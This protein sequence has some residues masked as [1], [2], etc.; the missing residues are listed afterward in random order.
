MFAL[1]WLLLVAVANG[2]YAPQQPRFASRARPVAA[3]EGSAA[4]EAKKRI[5]RLQC[6]RHGSNTAQKSKEKPDAK[7]RATTQHSSPSRAA[8]RRRQNRKH[9]QVVVGNGM[10]GQR[11]V[12]LCADKLAERGASDQVDIVSFCEER[13][14][15]YNRVRLTSWFETRDAD[16]LSLVGSYKD[17]PQ[18]EWYASEERPN[19]KVRV[20]DLATGLDVD[21]K[22]VACGDELVSYDKCVLATGSYPFVPPI[23]GK[24]LPGVFVYRTID[25][26]EA[27][28]AYQKAHGARAA[29]NFFFASTPS[30]R[31][32]KWMRRVDGASSPPRRER[33]ASRD[34]R[35]T[36]TRR[37]RRRG[38]SDRPVDQKLTK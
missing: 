12:E 24:D 34:E 36:P 2:L 13:L 38:E 17:A 6:L 3:A 25:D 26:L 10:V 20:G 11:L 4:A 1:S 27:L 18:G 31:G 32:N 33:A 8:F 16:D 5:A 15:A 19:C 22:T 28:V 7:A 9:T 21:K 23:P 35:T 37:R 30:R 14:A 29:R